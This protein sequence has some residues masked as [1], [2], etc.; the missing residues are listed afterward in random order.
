MEV[1]KDEKNV[2][3]LNCCGTIST[4]SDGCSPASSVKPTGDEGLKESVDLRK[5][6]QPQISRGQNLQEISKRLAS[7]QKSDDFLVTDVDGVSYLMPLSNEARGAIDDTN[8]GDLTIE[9]RAAGGTTQVQCAGI[10]QPRHLGEGGGLI[11]T[12]K[13]AVSVYPSGIVTCT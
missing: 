9:L 12:P 7:V 1:F 6:V 8:Y 5:D 2:F 3:S 10:C 13:C 11:Y 4:T